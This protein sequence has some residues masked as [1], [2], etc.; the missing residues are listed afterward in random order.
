MLNYVFILQK[1]NI[2]LQEKA[3]VEIFPEAGSKKCFR[4]KNREE[5]ELRGENA[6]FDTETA[7]FP[8]LREVRSVRKRSKI[9]KRRKIL[10]VVVRIDKK[11]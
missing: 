6:A 2:M 7:R 1:H 5:D 9:G 3:K 4:P 8:T 10:G 11:M